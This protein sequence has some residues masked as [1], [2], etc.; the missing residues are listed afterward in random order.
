M[1]PLSQVLV[2]TDQEHACRGNLD[3]SPLR[4]DAFCLQSWF[5]KTRA[6]A[7]AYLTVTPDGTRWFT[8]PGKMR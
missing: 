8:S 4:D 3:T 5:A 6:K 7:L 2:L 1:W